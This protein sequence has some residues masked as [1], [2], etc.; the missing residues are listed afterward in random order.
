MLKLKKFLLA[1][2]I[3]CVAVTGFVS[4]SNDDDEEEKDVY[5]SCYGTYTGTM[6]VTMGGNTTS[7]PLS[8]TV[9]KESVDCGGNYGTYTKVLWGKNAES[10]IF[11]A[12]QSDSTN[13]S[14]GDLTS[15]NYTTAASCII[16]FN[17]DNT[18]T[19]TVPAMAAMGG[20]ATITKQ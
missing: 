10:K 3:T 8:I 20:T 16:V 13:T 7:S 18:A 17:G 9:A 12:A 1:L 15:E 11:V 4:C 19:Y 2:M 6:N 14:K 5:E